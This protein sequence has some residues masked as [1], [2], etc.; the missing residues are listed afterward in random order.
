MR[1]IIVFLIGAMFFVQGYRQTA[2][3]LTLTNPGLNVS[4]PGLVAPTQTPYSPSNLTAESPEVGKV[5]LRWTDN[6]TNETGFTI[7][8]KSGSDDT[9]F[10]IDNEGANV[11]TYEQTELSTYAVFPGED[12]YYRVKAYNSNGS[13]G[14]SNEVYIKVTS[15]K[16]S[17]SPPAALRAKGMMVDGRLTV[18]L[19][20][21]DTAN[22]EDKYVVQRSKAGGGFVFAGELPANSFK[23]EEPA[24]L[25]R[26]VKYTYRVIA[27]NSGGA[28]VSNTADVVLPAS[29][30]VAPVFNYIQD[31]G[32]TFMLLTWTD[33]SNNED[34][35]KI[36]RWGD[37][38]YNP[39]TGETPPDK[40]Y[41]LDPNTTSLLVTGLTPIRE[42]GFQIVAYNAMGPSTL[43][44]VSSIT[45]PSAPASLA[46]TAES[47]NQTR[48]TWAWNGYGLVDSFSVE[49]K[50][51]GDAYAEIGTAGTA[52]RSYTDAPLLPGTQY[53]Y[54]ARAWSQDYYGRRYWS[55]YS[56]EMGITTPGQS[57]TSL[58]NGITGINVSQ[59]KVISFT[60][61]QRD[62]QV[63][64]I[65]MHMDTEAISR[66]GRTMLPVRYLAEPLGAVLAWDAASQKVTISLNSKVIELRIG[67]N[68]A[69]ING[70]EVLIDPGNH[71]VAP[72]ISSEG[73]TLLPLRFITENLGCQVDWNP[74]LQEVKI[75][76]TSP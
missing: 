36:T 42:Y 52:A 14:Y 57:T 68:T 56:S 13:S 59:R 15:N 55:D 70:Q 48:V 24:D 32:S 21:G 18:R 51:A 54:R 63:N 9:Y 3:A 1:L 45:G 17:P 60:L 10:P 20:W 73:R 65:T 39:F 34:G 64:G 44:S 67:N 43:S 7:E 41:L 69:L 26:N 19:F 11:T 31:Q 2:S 38:G 50:K 53:L 72:V 6:S 76:Y 35:F 61:G 8:R 37:K 40:E 27:Y 46:V 16:P 71:A 47:P 29:L 22:N 23:F 49:R 28:G 30:P 12:Y 25:E 33:K 66:E 75:N 74:V 5:V 58:Q 4:K 62:Y